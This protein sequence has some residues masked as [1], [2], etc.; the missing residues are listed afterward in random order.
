MAIYQDANGDWRDSNDTPYGEPGKV[1]TAPDWSRPVEPGFDRAY[2]APSITRTAEPIT[3]TPTITRTAP[4]TSQAQTDVAGPGTNNA[5]Y[6]K[7]LQDM[8]AEQAKQN[9]IINKLAQDKFDLEKAKADAV[10]AY[11]DSML[12]FQDRQLA[13]QAFDNSVL[14]AYRTRQ[15]ELQAEQQA[16]Q[17][18]QWGQQNVL[19]A[20]AQAQTANYQGQMVALQKQGQLIDLKKRRAPS[21]PRITMV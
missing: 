4:T 17:V 13:Q 5:A 1:I 11:N 6:T 7:Y 3:T 16:A 20:G 2:Q 18:G 8:A 15:S 19:A 21:A 9:A 14:A 10:T 12:K